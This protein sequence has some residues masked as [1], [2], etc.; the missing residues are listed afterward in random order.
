MVHTPRD[1]SSD[2][3]TSNRGLARR[4][5][6]QHVAIGEIRSVAT[7]TGGNSSNISGRIMI[8]SHV[9]SIVA[10]F[11]FQRDGGGH[12][13]LVA[14]IHVK[15][16]I[17]IVVFILDAPV[18]MAVVMVT[19]LTTWCII[20]IGELGIVV[21]RR[22]HLIDTNTRTDRGAGNCAATGQCDMAATS[23]WSHQSRWRR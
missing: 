20:G 22:I 14:Q 4:Q 3:A 23:S 16:A 21:G 19:R 10:A 11:S 7:G 15:L 8:S 1:G 13:R 6:H 5:R 12:D 18:M 2:G 9:D 17:V